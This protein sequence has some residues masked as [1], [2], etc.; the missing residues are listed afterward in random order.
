MNLHDLF[1]LYMHTHIKNK[2]HLPFPIVS[3]KILAGL[4]LLEAFSRSIMMM[5]REWWSRMLSA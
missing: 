1:L 2:A 3:P 4:L 5:R